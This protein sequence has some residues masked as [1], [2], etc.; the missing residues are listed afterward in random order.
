MPAPA[1]MMQ[2]AGVAPA[3]G[4]PAPARRS[5]WVG[6]LIGCGFALLLILV[7]GITCTVFVFN[8]K[9]FQRSFCSGYTGN[10]PNLTC[11]FNVAP[12]SP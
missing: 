9:D 7:L 5:P 10:N 11:P 12:A 6:I 2:P 1:P 4:A 8:N 3:Y